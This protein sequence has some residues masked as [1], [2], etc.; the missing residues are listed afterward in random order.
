M[1]IKQ[2]M[3]P[4]IYEF[5]GTFLVLFFGMG[6]AVHHKFSQLNF[7]FLAIPL[8]Y[9]M[10]SLASILIFGEKCSG[11]FNPLITFS[12]LA[13]RRLSRK[14]AIGLALSQ[15]LA[16]MVAAIFIAQLFPPGALKVTV[17]TAVRISVLRH[18]FLEF[19]A[20]FFFATIQLQLLEGFQLKG[21][22]AA[23]ASGMTYLLFFGGLLSITGCSVLPLR[24]LSANVLFAEWGKAFIYLGA[25]LL[26]G[27]AAV[28]LQQYVLTIDEPCQKKVT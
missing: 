5:F 10:A 28:W 14:V 17:V 26:G 6:A 19:G 27:A 12:A 18:F 1:E 11:H 3:A 4:Y 25:P 13:L 24:F 7:P 16:A 22:R 21:P 9:G 23:L 15:L 2:R 8:A 20:C